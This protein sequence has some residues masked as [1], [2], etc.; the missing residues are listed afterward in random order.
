MTVAAPLIAPV[1]LGVNVTLKVHLAPAASVAPHFFDPEGA[2]LKSPLATMLKMVRVA[3]ESL[4][5]V[6]VLAALVVP[7][8]WAANERLVGDRVAGSA[9]VP[10]TSMICGL[11]APEVAMATAPFVEPVLLGVNVTASVHFAD[12]ASGPPQGVAPLPV[13]EKPV[14]AL[15]A[16][17]VI[18]F[19][20][21]LVTVMVFGA[22][23]TPMPVA[24]KLRVGGL[25]VSGTVGP[26][27][28]VP[29]SATICG[30]SA[31]L[32]AIARPP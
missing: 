7:T 18:G 4:V 1:T 20:L 3:P 8:A 25:N 31:P 14:L 26:P 22:L 28:P 19:E 29:E 11:P 16:E 12:A 5:S 27:L 6:T 10:L 24:A 32:V 23:V 17:I 9:P 30:L 13:A 21:P 2:S 15:S